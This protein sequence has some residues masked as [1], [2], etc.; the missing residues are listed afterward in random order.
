MLSK[1]TRILIFYINTKL[2]SDMGGFFLFETVVREINWIE[3]TDTSFQQNKVQ[4]NIK[5]IFFTAS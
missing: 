2:T 1:V 5:D 3:L 4:Q